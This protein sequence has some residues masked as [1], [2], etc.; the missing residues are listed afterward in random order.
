[1]LIT[2]TLLLAAPVA[3]VA[4]SNEALLPEPLAPAQVVEGSDPRLA[5][6]FA[7]VR[8]LR[9]DVDATRD[10]IHGLG[11]R[12]ALELQDGFFVRGG[13]DYY[14]DDVDLMRLEL[15]IGQSVPLQEGVAAFASVSWVYADVDGGGVNGDENG[16]RVEAG[17][18]IAG[19]ES[20]E[21]EGRVGYED[22][23]DD[24]FLWGADV[25]YWFQSNV[26][27]GAGFEREV[28]DDVWTIGLRYAF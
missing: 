12:G 17:A 8:F 10:D 20:L 22:V 23:L 28:D 11:G 16:W 21:V 3:P 18:R 25:R 7:E 4:E 26:A 27:L 13:L 6:R 14:S 24:G 9:R 15:G 19:G 1:M 2:T 5:W